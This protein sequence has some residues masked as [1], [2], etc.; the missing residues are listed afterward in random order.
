MF[1]SEGGRKDFNRGCRLVSRRN[2]PGMA[3]QRL[4]EILSSL[5]GSRDMSG[6]QE[7]LLKAFLKF[8]EDL[9]I[10]GKQ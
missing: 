3:K 4:S 7:E 5:V 9:S 1:L 2:F 8:E 6:R 10:T